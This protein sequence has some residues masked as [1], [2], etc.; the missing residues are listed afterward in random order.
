MDD[1]SKADLAVSFLINC[2]D[3]NRNATVHISPSKTVVGKTPAPTV[4]YFSSRGPSSITPNILKA[5][6]ACYSTHEQIWP[7]DGTGLGPL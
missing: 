7:G 2:G 3:A 6:T 1:Q 5:L 4:A